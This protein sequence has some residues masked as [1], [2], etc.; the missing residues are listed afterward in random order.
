MSACTRC[1]GVGRYALT[2]WQK[3]MARMKV[4]VC[5]RCKGTGIEP[6]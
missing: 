1:D 3:Y 2:F 6:S 5:E 4:I